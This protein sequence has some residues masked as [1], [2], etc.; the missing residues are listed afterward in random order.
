[1]PIWEINIY[2]SDFSVY[3]INMKTKFVETEKPVATPALSLKSIW[4]L[5][6]DHSY[7]VKKG[8]N[9]PD[10]E[11]V[12]LKSIKGSGKISLEGIGD[13]HAKAGT[14]LITEHKRIRR[15]YCS[16]TEWDFYWFEFFVCDVIDLP[17]NILIKSNMNE[18]EIAQI[19]SCANY[20]QQEDVISKCIASSAFT[21]LLYRWL[22]EYNKFLLNSKP[23]EEQ[24]RSAAN[25][26]VNNINTGLT[27]Q[28]LS[29]KYGLCE[30]RF[31]Q[32]FYNVYSTTP[33]RYF[34]K[35][36]MHAAESL[37][38]KTNL[39]ISS[40]AEELAYSSQFHFTREFKKWY[41]TSPTKFR[42][43]GL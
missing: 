1:M 18:F 20:L 26:M 33:K 30:K 39:S 9:Y 15:Y 43:N 8:G 37:L 25:Y 17:K 34:D 13:L 41:N 42:K 28:S 31:R 2:I 40:I 6:A 32:L 14:L 36:R 35:L 29:Q 22:R 23:Y 24:I 16:S 10:N 21:G 4:I 38:K 5:Q 11:M 12:V 19:L 7:D 27:M 3:T